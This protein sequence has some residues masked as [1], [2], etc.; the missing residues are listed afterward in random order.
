MNRLLAGRRVLLA[1]ARDAPGR[2]EP[3]AALRVAPTALIF[4]PATP[5]W[6]NAG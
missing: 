6:L 2:D 3:S 1:H 5:M 4:R